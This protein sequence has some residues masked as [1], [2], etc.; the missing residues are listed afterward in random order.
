MRGVDA[1]GQFIEVLAGRAFELQHL[2]EV[3]PAPRALRRIE[4]LE[5]DAVCTTTV[6]K[7]PLAVAARGASANEVD[8]GGLCALVDAIVH[9]PLQHPRGNDAATPD[10]HGAGLVEQTFIDVLVRF[11][12]VDRAGAVV[13]LGAVLL[14]VGQELES[15]IA[16][17]EMHVLAAI[18]DAARGGG[19]GRRGENREVAPAGAAADH[20]DLTDA[21]AS[22]C[23][24][25]ASTLWRGHRT[26]C[27]RAVSS[28]R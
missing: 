13:V 5:P 12:R 20:A 8:D 23:S 10:E 11:E 28:S 1:T 25:C 24:G 15:G 14:Q 19:V 4:S 17:G 26:Q 3:L 9:Q 6:G 22:R 7:A 16:D 2:L 21:R 18:R 27:R